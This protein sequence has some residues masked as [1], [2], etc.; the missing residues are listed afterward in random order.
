MKNRLCK[1]GCGQQIVGHRNKK[2]INK[3]HKDKF[4]NRV[5]PRGYYANLV[6]KNADDEY[7]NDSLLAIDPDA[8]GQD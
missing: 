3:K 7:Y 4:W 8:L 5:N 1:C 6:I 2:F